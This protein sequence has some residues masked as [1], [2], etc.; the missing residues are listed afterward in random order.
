MLTDLGTL[1]IAENLK[2][3]KLISFTASKMA[4]MADFELLESLKL[5]SRKI[6]GI[7]KS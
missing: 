2:F 3:T 7:E 5:I 6:L 1:L 4:K